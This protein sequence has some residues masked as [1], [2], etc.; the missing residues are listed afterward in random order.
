MEISPN[1]TSMQWNELNLKDSPGDWDKAISVLEDRLY[2]RYIEPADKL[3]EIEEAL[4][5][6]ERR[7]GFTILAIDLLLIET[8]QAFKEG[9]SSTH[10]KSKAVFMR[11]L[12]ESSNFK[13]YFPTKTDREKFYK[14]FR[15][16]ILHQA[17]VQSNAL[18]WTIGDVYERAGDMEVLNRNKFHK[19]LKDDF[20]EYIAL[21]RNPEYTKLRT[22]FRKKMDFLA[23]RG[24]N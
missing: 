3:I 13:E 6:K 11:F 23:A 16:G 9:L 17:E 10:G 24:G 22:N 5:A 8:L 12:I 19:A 1:F 14:D 2:A 18:V 20:R 4:Q 15:C 21:L 7:F